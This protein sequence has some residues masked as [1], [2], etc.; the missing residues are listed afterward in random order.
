MILHQPM[1][2][3]QGRVT[4]EQA[5]WHATFLVFA[6]DAHTVHRTEAAKALAMLQNTSCHSNALRGA[7][8]AVWQQTAAEAGL[9][10]GT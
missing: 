1:R 6:P 3:W 10:D 9:Q 4:A 5:Q 7:K 2:V 8:Q